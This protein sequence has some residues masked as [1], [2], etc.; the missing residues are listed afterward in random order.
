MAATGGPLLDQR[1]SFAEA[2]TYARIAAF[3]AKGRTLYSRFTVST[4][5]IFLLTILPFLLLFATFA[6]KR[7]HV[8]RAARTIMLAFPVAYLVADLIEN[9]WNWIMLTDF[10]S[11]RPFL[12]GSVGFATTAKWIALMLAVVLPTA[13]LFLSFVGSVRSKRL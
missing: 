12:A 4:D 9:V 3:G 10:P 2:E 11:R 1:P 7:L 6:A 5:I 13:V 8:P